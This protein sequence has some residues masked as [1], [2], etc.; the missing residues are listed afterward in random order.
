MRLDPDHAKKLA[1]ALAPDEPGG[2]PQLRLDLAY[3]CAAMARL[4]LWERGLLT[5]AL[6]RSAKCRHRTIEQRI[7][8]A[9]FVSTE[10]DGKS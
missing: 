9:L 5:Q 10:K 2:P 4:T 7:L 8:L 3:M 6:M 1:A